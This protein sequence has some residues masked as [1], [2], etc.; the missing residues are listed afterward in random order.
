MGACFRSVSNTRSILSRCD[1]SLAMI[2]EKNGSFEVPCGFSSAHS[3]AVQLHMSGPCPGDGH[4]TSS[5]NGCRVKRK[6]SHQVDRHSRDGLCEA[7]IKMSSHEGEGIPGHFLLSLFCG[8][9]A[10]PA[11][12]VRPTEDVW[13]VP[14]PARLGDHHPCPASRLDGSQQRLRLDTLMGHPWC[15]LVG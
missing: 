12:R 4:V 14:V 10:R 15:C 5:E 13:T 3:D 11:P 2:S 6:K 8:R 9:Q 1:S 7:V